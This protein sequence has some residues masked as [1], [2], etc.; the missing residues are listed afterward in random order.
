MNLFIKKSQSCKLAMASICFCLA[1][2]ASAQITDTVSLSLP[3]A[4]K[5]FIDSNLNLLA[6]RYNID[7]N[8]AAILQARLW[9]NPNFSVGH[10]LY[11]GSLHQFFPIGANDETYASVSQ[12]ILLA[13]K[14]NKQIQLAEANTTL[15]EYQFFDLLRTLKYELHNNFYNIYFLRQSAK[16]YNSE[17]NALQ[18]IVTAFQQ[19]EGK[20]YIAESE[21]VRI[22]AQ[23]YSFTSEY[24]VLVNQITD[25]ESNLRLLVRIKP[26]TFISPAADTTEIEQLDPSRFSIATLLDSAYRNRTDL[27]IAK[28]NTNIN[29]LNYNYQKALAVPDLSVSVG[30]DEQGSFLNN[31]VSGGLGIDVP[32]FNRNQGNIRQAKIM[33]QNTAALQK[34]TE[35]TVAE[36]VSNAL[37]KAYVQDKMY[38]SIDKAFV[39]SFSH[40]LNEVMI[41]YQRRNISLLEFLDFY[42]SYKQNMLQMNTVE[43]NRVQA[44]EDINFYTATNFY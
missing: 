38:K 23:L 6:A 20:G 30:Y 33:I 8:R 29:Q 32:I 14:R 39:G 3:Q 41:N 21:V 26:S 37:Q 28:E 34:N 10:A 24:S 9:S 36:N 18:Q 12:L 1:F 4:E 19:Q 35:E 7:A 27:A 22:R 44:F 42:D 25:L 40:L 16:V 13:R 43:Y 17:I 31:L 11:S 15:T 5:L 2:S